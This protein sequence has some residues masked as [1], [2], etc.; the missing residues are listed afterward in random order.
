MRYKIVVILIL[1]SSELIFAQEG[2]FQISSS[3]SENLKDLSFS[4]ENHGWIIGSTNNPVSG[5]CIYTTD[6]GSSWSNKNFPGISLRQVFFKSNI[7]GWIL[8]WNDSMERSIL[9]KTV[10]GGNAWDDYTLGGSYIYSSIYFIENTVGYICGSFDMGLTGRIGV[11]YN[12]GT[13]WSY[14]DD[15]LPDILT[16]IWFANDLSG[17]CSGHDKLAA[18][19]DGGDNWDIIN[20]IELESIHFIN[21]DL[22]W[23][24]NNDGIHKTTNGGDNWELTSFSGSSSDIFF[25]NEIT[26]WAATGSMIYKTINGGASWFLQADE[27]QQINAVYFVNSDTGYAIGNNGLILKTI[28]GGGGEIPVELTSFTASAQGKYIILNWETATELNNFGFKIYRKLND[29]K[30]EFI[31][32]TEGNGTS[33]EPH[34]YIFK[35]YPCQ[36][37]EYKY[38]LKQIDY[39]GAEKIYESGNVVYNHYQELQISAF[40]NP[41][42]GLLNIEYNAPEGGDVQIGVFSLTGESIYKTI[43]K[44]NG[45]HFRKAQIDM[46]NYNSGIYILRIN[47][48]NRTRA[49]KVL[50][51]K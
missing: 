4:D 34:N 16:C 49:I 15:N 24:R 29:N 37:G 13:S 12:G 46:N 3:S 21:D 48:K 44:Y 27:S 22:G 43:D 7:H 36:N 23:G 35:D 5:F 10:D 18:T 20:D 6:G 41:F 1:F 25:I 31:N 38:Q 47:S 17:W 42:N 2:W 30:F 33:S 51:V 32:F 40:P 11:S 50:M 26:G 19:T 8:G 39:N 9:Q 28:D 14:I 45:E